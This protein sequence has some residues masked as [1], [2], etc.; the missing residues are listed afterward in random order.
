MRELTI[1][2][3][4]VIG[5]FIY[6]NFVRKSLYLEL[7]TSNINNK[8]YYVRKLP[9]SQEAADKLARLTNSLNRL[10][11][12]V[13]DDDRDGVDRLS[14]KFKSD[15]ITENIPGSRFVAYSVN[16]GDELSICIREVETEKFIDDN[17]IIFVAIHELAHIMTDDMGHTDEFWDN[18][19]YLLEKAIEIN[20]YSY[21]DYS[22]NNVDYCGQPINS[23]PLNL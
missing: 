2:M 6:V 23:T 10:I 3:I 14:K 12:N 13:K 8:K 4:V 11:E 15:I 9:D 17:T 20:I 16:K 18:M 1:L 5:I 7:V 19:K 21:V 22:K